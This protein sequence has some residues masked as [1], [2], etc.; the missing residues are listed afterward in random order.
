MWR[1]KLPGKEMRELG[2]HPPRAAAND[3]FA[4][5]G[6][7]YSHARPACLRSVTFVAAFLHTALTNPR[8]S[9]DFSRS[10]AISP[11][12][13]EQRRELSAPFPVPGLRSTQSDPR[14]GSLGS[15]RV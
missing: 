8:Q 11:E 2:S 15:G 1:K 3:R 14:S 10:Q 6:N 5:C 9:S 13:P 4:K 12:M 7:G